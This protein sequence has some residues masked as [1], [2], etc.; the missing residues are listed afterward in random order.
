MSDTHRPADHGEG[1]AWANTLQAANGRHVAAP[2]YCTGCGVTWPGELLPDPL[3]DPS[4]VPIT[5][6]R[7]DEQ[8]QRLAE[9]EEDRTADLARELALTAP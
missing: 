3:P 8:L 7:R 1:Y 6:R 2:L 9:R 5:T 4:Y